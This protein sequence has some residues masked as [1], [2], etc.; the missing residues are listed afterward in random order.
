MN[1]KFSGGK[2]TYDNP[3]IIEDIYDFN[4]I[5]LY[6]TKSY[7]L[8]NNIDFSTPPFNKGFLPIPNF[9]GQLDGN[10]YKLLNIYINQPKNNDV[11]LFQSIDF[12]TNSY[13]TKDVAP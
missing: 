10:G 13:A 7:K 2:G 12:Y 5:R 11:G 9:T 8:N 1:G 4:N 3:Y 6:P